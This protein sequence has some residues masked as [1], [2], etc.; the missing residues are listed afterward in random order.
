M[1]KTSLFIFLILTQTLYAALLPEEMILTQIYKNAVPA[2]VN[3]TSIVSREN[4]FFESTDIPAGMGSGILW[5]R[6]GY[7]VTNAHVVDGST[8]L[9]VT[10]NGDTKQYKAKLIGAAAQKD[11]AVI[12]LIEMPKIL[13]P[14]SVGRSNDLLVG[15]WAIAI[16]NPFGLDHSMSKGIISALDRKIDGYGGVK[17]H[18]MIQTD[19]A[20]NQGNSGGPLLNSSGELIGMNAMIFSKSGTSAGLGFAVPVDTI[21]RTVPDL[22]K[23]G[24]E[25]RPALGISMLED[26][27][28]LRYYGEKG[29]AVSYVAELGPAK[30]AGLRG[31]SKDQNGRI[32]LGDLLL[33]INETEINSHDDIYHALDKLKIG[34]SVKIT[35]SR[36]GKK[37]TTNLKL[38]STNDIKFE[39]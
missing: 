31:I 35:Y 8:S 21:T 12:K 34:D 2:V 30:K 13:K 38:E 5:N 16:G 7:I 14:I 19:A 18:N 3:I 33:K 17:I 6:E 4:I 11:I 15:Q 27:M 1:K 9:L 26:Y 24:K 20:I 10:F 25:V 37:L 28:K 22:I 23:Y 29:V 36:E 39:K 32:Y